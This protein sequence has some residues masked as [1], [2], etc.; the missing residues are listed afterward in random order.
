LHQLEKLTRKKGLGISREPGRYA[1]YRC[2]LREEERK[3]EAAKNVVSRYVEA[4]NKKDL[5]LLDDLFDESY[6]M[7]GLLVFGGKEVCNADD[8]K[9][10]LQEEFAAIPDLRI[11]ID[12]ILT[13]GDRVAI[14]YTET[15]TPIGKRLAGFVQKGKELTIKGA[16][17]YRIEEDKIVEEWC[18]ER[19]FDVGNR[20]NAATQIR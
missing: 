2:K 12:D 9:W 1:D 5:D 3:A 13:E 7:N 18:L 15:G 20:S 10:F 11:S 8:L 19:K 6:V 4:L 17:I 14:R 16:S